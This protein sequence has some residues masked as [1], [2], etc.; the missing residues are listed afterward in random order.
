MAIA[1]RLLFLFLLIAVS[2]SRVSL[3]QR[4]DP[5]HHRW[6]FGLCPVWAIMNSAAMSISVLG[7]RHRFIWTDPF[8]LHGLPSFPKWCLSDVSEM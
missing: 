6:A 2:Y 4:P 7:F 1:V 3:K 5:F 8:Q